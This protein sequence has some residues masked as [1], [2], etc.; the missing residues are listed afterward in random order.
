MNY[1]PNPEFRF[2]HVTLYVLKKNDKNMHRLINM[3]V[4]VEVWDWDYKWFCI[5]Y[6]L[7]N[8]LAL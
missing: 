7:F 6:F 3:D 5:E 4:M 2:H 8:M 1:I